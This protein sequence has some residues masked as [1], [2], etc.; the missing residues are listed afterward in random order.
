MFDQIPPE[1]RNAGPGFAGAALALFF[2]RRTPWVMVGIS[3]CGNGR[4]AGLTGGKTCRN[5]KS[6]KNGCVSA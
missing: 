3:G 4:V 5:N 6:K 1:L 2:M